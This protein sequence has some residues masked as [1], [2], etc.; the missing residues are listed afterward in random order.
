MKTAFF[1]SIAKTSLI[2][3]CTL[4]WGAYHCT[5]L[6]SNI[7]H[8]RHSNRRLCVIARTIVNDHT[9]L[10][11]RI[12]IHPEHTKISWIHCVYRIDSADTL[13]RSLAL[14]LGCRHFSVTVLWT[15]MQQMLLY[16]CTR[17]CRCYCCCCCFFILSMYRFFVSHNSKGIGG[18]KNVS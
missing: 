17:N 13:S 16:Q 3:H 18:T 5:R 8:D 9:L 10:C 1:V 2:G 15:V 14:T 6:M 7:I 4:K 12:L 11:L